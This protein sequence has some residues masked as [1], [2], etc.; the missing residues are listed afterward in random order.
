V[1]T[2][3]APASIVIERTVEWSDTDASGRVHNSLA[4]R[5]Q[6]AAEA[7][8]LRRAGLADL[9]PH[10]PRVRQLFE[11]HRGLRFGQ[12]MAVELRLGA[13]GRTSL[14]WNLSVRGPDGQVAITGE[15][16]VVHVPGESAAPWPD[17]FRAA[18]SPRS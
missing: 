11:F 4:A 5:L 3:G 7:E 16:V 9:L 8:L 2:A 10:M 14:T 12:T 1:S 13:L 17:G 15:V 6:E 18:L